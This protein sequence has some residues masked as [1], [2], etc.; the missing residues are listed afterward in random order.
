[1]LYRVDVE[2]KEWKPLLTVDFSAMAPPWA[3]SP[4]EQT[5]YKGARDP[6]NAQGRPVLNLPFD[7][8]LVLDLKT[9][10]Q[11]QVLQL[12]EAAY[13]FRLS[14]DGRTFML[15]SQPDPQKENFHLSRISVDGSG[16]RR[17]TE[18][19]GGLGSAPVGRWT[20]D[21]RAYF[22]AEAVTAA[23][24]DTAK[25]RMM[26]IPAEGGKPEFTGMTV[27]GLGG[28]DLSPDGSRIAYSATTTR[29]RSE[30]W[31]LDNI[32]FR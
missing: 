13:G 22:F 16:Y 14:P 20:R 29:S 23:P 3:I 30:L 9:G 17:L 12:P 18:P 10:A 11:K 7:R 24:R 28:F 2:S 5:L 1:V 19:A 32:N 4:D 6:K 26:R 8:I 27:T 21:S 25:S 31:A 15:T